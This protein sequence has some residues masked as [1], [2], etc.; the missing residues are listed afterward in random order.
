MG[1]SSLAMKPGE[2][3]TLTDAQLVVVAVRCALRT[4]PW[5]TTIRNRLLRWSAEKT[6]RVAVK[7][8][9]AGTT[10]RANVN[11]LR[12][13]SARVANADDDEAGYALLTLSSACAV[14]VDVKKGVERKLLVKSV[15]DTGKYAASIAAMCAHA[16]RVKAAD[17]KSTGCDDLVDGALVLVWNAARADVEALASGKTFKALDAKL[18]PKKAPR[19][20]P[21]SKK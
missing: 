11:V 3:R 9:T 12:T 2:L 18:W 19:F 8:V 16:G 17:I 13:I 5:L 6:W 4:E 10:L 21:H 7:D 15:I 1:A 14:A 20:W